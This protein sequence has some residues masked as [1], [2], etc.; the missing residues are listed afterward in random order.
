MSAGPAHPAVREAPGSARVL[1]VDDQKRN[2]ELWAR[3]IAATE[4][5]VSEAPDGIAALGMTDS[6]PFDLILLDVHMPGIDGYEVC[7]RLKADPR[8]TLIPIIITSAL[9]G[10]ESRLRAIEAGAADFLSWPINREEVLARVR[11]LL[12]LHRLRRRVIAAQIAEEER[13]RRE[14]RDRLGRYF[15]PAILDRILGSGPDAADDMLGRHHRCRAVALFADLRG[16]TRVSEQLAPDLV[17]SLLNQ[18]FTLLTSAATHEDGTVF[19]MAGDSLLVG[20]GVPFTQS[21][22][23]KRA[24]RTSRAMIESF[25]ALAEKWHAEHD[26]EVGIGVGIDEG[27]VVLGNVGAED[28]MSYT[29]IGHAVNIASRIMQ[30]AR[31]GEALLSERVFFATEQEALACGT[32]PL[33]LMRLRGTTNE[34]QLYCVPRVSRARA[35]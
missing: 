20:F 17:A 30:R 26:V 34:I 23:P 24:L 11:S 25:D 18:F 7:R 35:E 16:F 2:R 27:D 8:T 21:D 6:T 22:A 32:V 4:V 29:I 14:M 15:S 9:Q 13:K 5:V 19:G 31:A 1:I 10:S 3:T 33:P 28:F 12:E